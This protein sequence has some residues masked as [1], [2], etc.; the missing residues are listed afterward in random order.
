VR[1]SSMRITF[2]ATEGVFEADEYALICGLAGVDADGGEHYLNLQRS[3][4]GG[5]AEEDW[6]VHLEFDDQINGEYGRVREWRL[7]RD[8]L[9]VDL[10]QQLG[11]MAG[12]GGFDVA[13][14]IDDR[15]FEQIRAGLLRIFREPTAV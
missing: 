6:G 14:A 15:A 4:E 1:E 7:S 2:R 10:S 11:T 13:L 12:V 8:Q 3:S 9:A 5:P